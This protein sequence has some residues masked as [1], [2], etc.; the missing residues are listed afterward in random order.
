[1]DAAPSPATVAKSYRRDSQEFTPAEVLSEFRTSFPG[2]EEEA[3]RYGLD[4][5]QSIDEWEDA[6]G[7]AQV[8]SIIS[9]AS[10]PFDVAAAIGETVLRRGLPLIA[11]LTVEAALARRSG[12]VAGYLRSSGTGLERVLASLADRLGEAFLDA[13][14]RVTWQRRAVFARLLEGARAN[15]EWTRQAQQLSGAEPRRGVLTR[16]GIAAVLATRFGPI[17]EHELR[18]ARLMLLDSHVQGAERALE[19]YVEASVWLYDLFEDRSAISEAA[20]LVNANP[21]SDAATSLMAAHLWLRLAGIASRP[22]GVRGFLSRSRAVLDRWASWATNRIEDATIVLLSAT[23][24]QL[25]DDLTVN[26]SDLSTRGILFPFGHRR[27]DTPTAPLFERSLP[28]LA[29]SLRSSDKSGDF[30]FRDLRAT[31]LALHARRAVIPTP[32]A[33]EALDEAIHARDGNVRNRVRPLKRAGIEAD[34]A[35]DRFLLANLTGND[36]IRRLGFIDLM[37]ASQPEDL[38]PRYL[39]MIAKEVEERGALPGG[40][41]PGPEEIA[42][43]IRRGDHTALFEAAARAAYSSADLT[44]VLLGGRGEVVTLRDS[45][46]ISGQTFV[47]KRTRPEAKARDE[48][49]SRAVASELEQQ[50]LTSGFGLIDHLTEIPDV[51]NH[52]S[53]PDM[54]VSVRR[55]WDGVPLLDHLMTLEPAD[56]TAILRE[57]SRFLAAIHFAGREIVDTNGTRASLKQ[58]EFGRWLR[59]LRLTDDERS[60]VF[61][62]WWRIVEDAPQVPRRDAHPLNWIVGTDDKILAVD[63]ES[64]GA[65]PFGYELAQLVEDGQCLLPDAYDARVSI[66]EAYTEAWVN[67]SGNTV[68]SHRAREWYDAGAVARGVRALSKPDLEPSRR[69]YGGKLLSALATYSESERVREIASTL[70]RRWNQMTGRVGKEGSKPLSEADRRR[71]SRAMS[72]H[73][74]HD[75][76]APATKTGWMHVDDLVE[77]MRASGHKVSS[78]QLLLIAGALGEPRFELDEE[79]IRAAYGHSVMAQVEYEARRAPRVLFHATPTRNLASV[80]EA[81]AGLTPGD[82]NWVHLTESCEVAVNA[83]RR[84]QAPVCVLEVDAPAVAG[85]VH[86]SG[87]TWL[88]PVVP[89]DTLRILPIRWVRTLTKDHR[90]MPM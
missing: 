83:A 29:H 58:I 90:A 1:M 18:D 47:Y 43:A 40:L 59:S 45:D 49:Y 28:R 46:G 23:I 70:S 8:Q 88:A 50:G 9:A 17:S 67:L 26:G 24:D 16:L 86:A 44:Q 31:F 25:E 56:T 73:L 6:S 79:E 63:L 84:Q 64:K 14:F 81:R 20:K 11:Y 80:F 41:V 57:V 52:S 76:D 54:I 82:R 7:A 13:A 30:I 51:G 15:L 62:D 68:S 75:V 69:A 36:D 72:Y 85:L 65:R 35:A 34:Q 87:A 3:T 32:S 19:Y 89:I 4:L 77:V 22:S 60:E 10:S 27:S 21:A 2:L 74:R 42:I 61:N 38:Q 66:V 33:V 12:G 53:D 78:A 55:F 71:I 48:E 37:R 5:R 39:T